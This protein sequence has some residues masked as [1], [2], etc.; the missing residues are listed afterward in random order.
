MFEMFVLMLAVAIQSAQPPDRVADAAPAVAVA[1]V[2]AAPTQS[3][4]Q[5]EAAPA[6]LAPAP[7]PASE[8]PP[9]FLA[10]PVPALVAEP[11][12]PTGRFTTA[13]EVKPILDVT[14]G[15]WIAV[16]EFNG[17]DLLYV[18]HLW[19]WRCGL[20]ELKIGINGAPPEPWPLP[21]CH[22]DQQTPNAILQGDGDP[23]RAFTLGSVAMVEV[24][25]TYDDLSTD[26]GKYNRQGMAI[27]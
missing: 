24:R 12:V 6:F 13:V 7:A 4:P 5:A 26:G 3:A 9:V 23:Y 2:P 17:Q 10:P 1:T 22:M 25:L 11:Q 18:T 27:R 16:R 20:L 14:R 19:S 15:N 8:A 21:Q